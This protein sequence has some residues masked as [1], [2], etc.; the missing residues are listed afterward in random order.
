MPASGGGPM[1]GAALSATATSTQAS[2]GAVAQVPLRLTVNGNAHDLKIDP[3]ESLLDVLRERL[4][5]TGTKKGCNQ[6]AC[7]ACTVLV[8]GRRINSYLSLAAMHNG[9][10]VQTIEGLSPA[11]GSLPPLQ[12]AFVDA[13]RSYRQFV[14]VC[15]AT[16]RDCVRQQKTRNA[17]K[18]AGSELF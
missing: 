7:G 6:G 12:A 11:S 1:V 3:R 16:W 17:R 5:L 8:N 10:S 15:H 18:H 2:T 9:A 14:T 4:D 13:V